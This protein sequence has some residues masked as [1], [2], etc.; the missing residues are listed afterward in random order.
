MAGCI[1]S[2]LGIPFPL[3]PPFFYPGPGS[4]SLGLPPVFRSFSLS[5]FLFSFPD[6]VLLA[7]CIGTEQLFCPQK[8]LRNPLFF[9]II[10]TIFSSLESCRASRFIFH[11]LSR[12]DSSPFLVRSPVL[13]LQKPLSFSPA[14]PCF[15][16]ST[17]LSSSL[18]LYPPR[19]P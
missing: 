10:F 18:S 1:F 8:I 12:P 5:R 9:P 14:R 6:R 3:A 16:K 11:A 7:D 17:K 19:R 4:F 13:F 2:R 15:A